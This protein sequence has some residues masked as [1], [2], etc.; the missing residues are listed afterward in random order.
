FFLCP[1]DALGLL[2]HVDH[3]GFICYAPDEGTAIDRNR[4]L[5][6]IR[7]G[8]EQAL[9]VLAAGM[10]HSNDADFADEFQAYWRQLPDVE[11]MRSV[12]DPADNVSVVIVAPVN[13]HLTVGHA[14][15]D[16]AAFDRQDLHAGP[17]DV[18]SL[19]LPLDPGVPFLPPAPTQPWT[20]AEAREKLVG[21][22]SAANR[23]MLDQVVEKCA[24]TKL[25]KK[26]RAQQYVFAR[27]CRPSGGA[28]L[29]GLRFEQTSMTHPLLPGGTAD[30]VVPLVLQR[31]D[32]GF[33]LGRGGA[34]AV[35]ADA[36]VLLVGCGAV[37]GHVAFELVRAG[38]LHLTV[39]DPDVL[40]SDNTF[41]HVLGRPYWRTFK[42][43]AVKSAL[44]AEF[45]YVTVT[46]LPLSIEQAIA[47]GKLQMG[48]FHLVIVAIGKPTVELDL[49]ERLHQASAG[50][51]AIF[52][53]LEPLGI[54]GHAIVVNNGPGRG[55][56]ACLY[57]SPDG[58]PHELQNRAAFAAPG[59]RFGRDL[60]GCGTLF[61]PF[62]SLDATRTALVAVRLGVDILQGYEQGNP[63]VSWK[64][65]ATAFVQQGFQLAPRFD[66]DV[67]ELDAQRDKY[68]A[69]ACPV[70]G[71]R[72]LQA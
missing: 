19:Y 55:C 53:W 44:E 66:L 49:N 2:P 70:C 68:Q 46:A 60:E 58:E 47:E 41:R 4:P 10:A 20:V 24:L 23:T 7:E 52:T 14:L 65:D 17:T 57:T 50:P 54:G 27:L 62:G 43:K 25:G 29:F 42:A 71:G 56:F 30:R 59:Q 5:D 67:V 38:V 28:T 1:P 51:P 39:A 6:V 34:T 3:R 32:R 33:L 36:R 61:T 69:G 11:E 35:R 26:R 22:L 13:G 21:A 37:G 16:I 72:E 64:G 48:N 8:L 9:G 31:L 40:T 12:L 18:R 15:R 63:L 45:P